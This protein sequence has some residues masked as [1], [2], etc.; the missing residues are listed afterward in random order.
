MAGLERCAAPDGLR[1]MHLDTATNQPEAMAFY[2]AQGYG[3][4][5]PFGT[6]RTHT[7]GR[8]FTKPLVSASTPEPS[9]P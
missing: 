9:R 6:Y 5:A 2:A 1:S 8:Y 7:D 3:P 4:L